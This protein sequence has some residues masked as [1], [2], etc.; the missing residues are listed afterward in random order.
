MEAHMH[1]GIGCLW[2]GGK[3]WKIQTLG[4][5]RLGQVV[6]EIS[7]TTKDLKTLLEIIPENLLDAEF[8]TDRPKG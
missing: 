8:G 2:L 5:D 6:E 7:V 4:G 1:K 3:K